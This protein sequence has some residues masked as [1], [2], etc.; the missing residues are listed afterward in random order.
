MKHATL[1]A[2]A[3]CLCLGFRPAPAPA[4][5]GGEGAA[6]RAGG[7]MPKTIVMDR[8]DGDRGAVTFDHAGHVDMASGCGDCHHQHG[9]SQTLSCRECHDLEPAAFRRAVVTGRFRPCAEC[10]PASLR[11]DAP[12]V[13][14]LAAAYHRACFRCHK[15]VGSVGTDPKGCAEMCHSRDALAKGDGED[16]GETGAAPGGPAGSTR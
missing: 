6:P 15:E 5:G 4:A 7:A 10:H 13:P 16:R 3:L 11:P 1:L 2:F 14:K 8:I 12:E 9:A